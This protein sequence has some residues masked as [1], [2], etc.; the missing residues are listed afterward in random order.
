MKTYNRLFLLAITAFSI[1]TAEGQTAGKKYCWENL[2]TAIVPAF[3]ADTFNITLYGAKPDGQTLNTKSINN[4]IKDCSKKGGGVVLVPGGVW[5]TGPVEMQNNVNL[6]ISRSAI[7][8]FS[9]DFNQYP[10]VKGNYEGKPSMRNQSPIC[11][12]NLENIAITGAGVLDGNGDHW[13]MVTKDRLTERKWKEKIASG[14]LLSE[15]GRTWF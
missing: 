12:A 7:L 9:S 4:A 1:V 6:H 8:L 5:L 14:G 13:R 11:G 2:P 10:L 3:K 15:D